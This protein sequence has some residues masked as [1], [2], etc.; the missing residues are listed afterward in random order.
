MGRIPGKKTS[1]NGKEIKIVICF[2]ALKIISMKSLGR[3]LLRMS[4]IGQVRPDLNKTNMFT[5]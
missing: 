5:T 3:I 4:S 1:N 2:F